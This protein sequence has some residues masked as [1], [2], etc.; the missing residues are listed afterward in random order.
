MKFVESGK[1]TAMAF[2]F[3]I[4]GIYICKRKKLECALTFRGL[5]GVHS[6]DI[7]LVIEPKPKR[8]PYH[9]TIT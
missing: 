5:H 4:S 8:D 3:E 9:V 7:S 2:S 1:P 6:L